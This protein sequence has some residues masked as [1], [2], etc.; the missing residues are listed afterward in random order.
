[1]AIQ[2]KGFLSDP[3][4]GD[5]DTTGT[6]AKEIKDYITTADPTPG[7]LTVTCKTIGHRIFTLVVI[8]IT[9][10]GG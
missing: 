10:G 8:E 2:S 5:S 7:E 1:M 3:I 6:Y 4:A 9:G